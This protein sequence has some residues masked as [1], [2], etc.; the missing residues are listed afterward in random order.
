[1]RVCGGT[2]AETGVR[3]AIA[4]L[5]FMMG[6]ASLVAQTPAV[7]GQANLQSPSGEPVSLDLLVRDR[8]KKPVLD[9]KPEEL[10]V[11]DNG[12]PARLTDL[13]LVNGDPQDAPLI[14]LLFDRPGMEDSERRAEDSL[15]G[16]SASSARATSKQLR[17]MASR[18]L[19]ALPAGRF[20]F[21]VV[22]VWG[23]LQIQQ[24]SSTNRRATEE[25]IFTAVEPEV[26]GS[27][28]EANAVERRL[29]QVAKTER[30]SSGTV[31]S[32][33]DRTLARSM[34]TALQTSGHIAKDQ[35]L[36]A[37]Q[38]S[39]MALV[40]AQQSLPGRKVIVYFTSIAQGSGDPY[41][42]V[43][44]DNHAKEGF[45]SIAGAANRAGVSI[46]VVL[47]DSLRDTSDSD[48]MA[49]MSSADQ[50]GGIAQMN[51]GPL[52][53]Q[54]AEAVATQTLNYDL[55]VGARS[56]TKTTL[57]GQD[58]MCLLAKQ[59]GG[60]ILIGNGRM[61]G[62]LK[63]LVQNL[64]TYYEASFIPPSGREDGSFHATAFKT[65]R[66]GLTMRAGTGYV[67]MPPTAGITDPLQPFEVP[68]I[69]LLSRP[70]L[71]GDVDYRARVMQMEHADEGNVALL[72]LEVPVSGLE[73]RTDTSTRLSSAHVSVLAT[74]KDGAGTQIERFSED[75]VRRW[76]VGSSGGTAPAFLS[77]ERSFA[78]TP[79]TYVLETAILDRN[80]GKAAVERQTFECPSSQAVP[81][82][83][84]LMVVRGTDLQEN[85]SGEPDLLWRGE[86]RV[87]PNLYGE[88]PAGAHDISIFFLAHTDP[89]ALA[90]ATVKL[91]VL[92]DGRPMKGEPPAAAL[93]AGD[94]FS[95]VLQ[96][97]S[98]RS[99]AG[100]KYEVRA[101]LTQGEKSVEKTEEFVL[102]GE[103]GLTARNGAEPAGDPAVADDAPEIAPAGQ[104]I[105]RPTQ[106]ELDGILA[107]AR[108]HA[109]D[110][111]DALPNLICQETTQRYDAMGNGDWR[112]KDTSVEMLTYLNHKESRTLVGQQTLGEVS[113]IGVSSSGEFGAALTNI[114]KPESKAQFAWKETSMLHGEPAEVFDY[115]VEQQNSPFMLNALPE[116]AAHVAYHGRIYIDRATHGVK[117]L[118]VITDE[119]PKKF[120]IR[121]AAIRIDYDYV[122]INEHDYLLPVSAQ[123]VTKVTGVVGDVLRRNDMIFSGFHRFGSRVRIVGVDDG[124]EP[125]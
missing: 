24:E 111:G 99:A 122:A 34:Y 5:M 11:A 101:T 55:Q 73:V 22:D 42:R 67:A 39:L 37:S 105:E 93:K 103:E 45:K 4:A 112:L 70:Q 47:P 77:F 97:F 107:D 89:K 35:N 29:M 10:T 115:R 1:M 2:K 66:R 23:R 61:T 56:T 54:S 113:E 57:F 98:I 100:G 60:D 81:A 41:Y 28:I 72:A 59:T 12:K 82:L 96:V 110:Y 108:T 83:S 71:P 32:M 16:T 58:N 124:V 62:P 38:A 6:A 117:S 14:T 40:E 13:R 118:T 33:Q 69:A 125:Q 43:D 65:S 31:A 19:K 25:S 46:Y 91:E 121:R 7:T 106:E 88:L 86:R 109:L 94:E 104:A 48:L 50:M 64:T 20:R 120:P 123:V 15:F 30:D 49:G 52:A 17:Q 119:Q 85:G 18:F 68:L 3:A 26:Y 74:I 84:D 76:S 75:I 79:G 53:P 80:S 9:L 92:R 87:L 90:P 114:F 78:A 102:A 36:S 63:S 27:K 8:H 116:A 21:A 44:S 95:Q 51:A